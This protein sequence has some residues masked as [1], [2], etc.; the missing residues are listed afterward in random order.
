MVVLS[1]LSACTS[2]GGIST[3]TDECR[4]VAYDKNPKPIIRDAD[5]VFSQC[6]Q[7]KET[8]REQK[9]KEANIDRWGE[10]IT[11]LLFPKKG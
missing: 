3:D 11:D 8:L 7:Q 4:Q 1:F 5:I 2:I 10:F 9:A 6:L